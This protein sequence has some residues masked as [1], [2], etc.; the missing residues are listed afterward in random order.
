MRWHAPVDDILG[1]K[2]KVR[3]LRL[4]FLTRG[5]YTGRE[6]AKLAG[7]SPTHT[8]A[9]LKELEI[10]GVVNRRHAG[11][12]DLYSLNDRSALASGVLSPIFTWEQSLF[13][14][15]AHLYSEA[16]GNDLLAIEIFGSV[17]R[18]EEG[19][20]SDVDL[21]IVIRDG[22]DKGKAEE[23]VAQ[24]S[25]EAASI[26]GNQFSPITVTKKELVNKRSKKQG[27][28]RGL[29]EGTVTIYRA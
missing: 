18:G 21:L 28:W 27:V 12:A 17:A 22:A 23:R 29:S 24:A 1:S 8:I 25:V 10:I 2:L 20:Q 5:L 6:M 9:A 19:E 11:N 3:I 26:F 4:L 16:L 14:Q 7:Y 13:D 15:L